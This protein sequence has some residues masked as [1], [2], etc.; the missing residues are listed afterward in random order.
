[1]WPVVPQIATPD[2]PATARPRPSSA[3]TPCLRSC[4]QASSYSPAQE[5]RISLDVSPGVTIPS[6]SIQMRTS[7][8][9]CHHPPRKGFFSRRCLKQT[10]LRR[11]STLIAVRVSSFLTKTDVHCPRIAS[12]CGTLRLTNISPSRISQEG[13]STKLRDTWLLAPTS[14]LS[15][16]LLKQELFRLGCA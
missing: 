12:L 14:L 6:F 7:L 9:L 11:S 13:C 8:I 10:H 16:V 1:M 5:L 3:T 2:R 15:T 4:R